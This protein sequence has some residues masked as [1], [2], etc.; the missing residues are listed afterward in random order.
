M[1]PVSADAVGV[2]S[3]TNVST[4][5]FSSR[6]ISAFPTPPRSAHTIT[7]LPASRSTPVVLHK[8]NVGR[9]CGTGVLRGTWFAASMFPTTDVAV[10]PSETD[11]T[12]VVSVTGPGDTL[13]LAPGARSGRLSYTNWTVCSSVGN[14][15][16]FKFSSRGMSYASRMAANI[17]A[18]LTVSI[19]RSASRSRSRSSMSTG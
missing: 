7:R 1:R 4:P 9:R 2:S 10:P 6:P 15:P 8:S 16:S 5:N 3:M 12:S 13:D 19:P 11:R 14:S 18:C 17:S